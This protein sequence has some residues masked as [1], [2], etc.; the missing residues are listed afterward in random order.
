[1]RDFGFSLRESRRSRVHL[2]R[3][4]QSV[5]RDPSWVSVSFTSILSPDAVESVEKGWSLAEPVG[6]A[7][8]SGWPS[9]PCSGVEGRQYWDIPH[10]DRVGLS[11]SNDGSMMAIERPFSDP[12][13]RLREQLAS[14][15]LVLDGAMGTMVQSLNLTDADIRGPRFLHHPKDLSRFVDLMAISQP[16]A[17]ADIHRAYLA[18]GADIVTTN[19]F[20]ASPVGAQEFDLGED[21]IREINTAAVQA[22]RIAADEFTRETPRRPRFVA[23]SIGPTAKQMA[24]STRVEDPAHRDVTFQQMAASYGFQ[25][26]ALVEAGVD[27]LLVETV[28]D[29][30]NAKACL[31]AIAEY[32]A[33]TSRRVPV[34]VSGTFNEGVTFV[35]SQSVEAFW[36]A[37]SHFPLLAVGMNCALGPE[38]MRSMIQELSQVATVPISCHPNAGLPNEMGHYDLSPKAMARVLNEFLREGWLN[39]VGGCCGTTPDHIRAIAA[40]AE[41]ARPHLPR[42]S[43]HFTQLS[44]TL[45]LTI[46]PDANFT[47]IGERTNVTGSRK[48]ANL[49]RGNRY[50]EAVEVARQQVQSG[51]SVIDVNM[52]DALLDGE[53]AITRFLHLIAGETDI[54]G[55]PVMVDSSN[56][57]VLEAGLRCLQGKGIVNSI[58]LKDGEEEFLRRA[59]LVRRYGAAAVVMA[60]DEQGQAVDAER[61]VTICERAYRLLTQ[62]VGFPPQDII[63][64]PNILTVAT[65]IEEHDGYAISFM[66]AARDIKRRCPYAKVSGGVSNISFSFRGNDV[67]REAMHAAFLYHA[68]RA[69]L[70][71]GIVNA[72]QLALYEDIPPELKAHVE[73]VLLNRRSDATDRLLLLADSVKGQGSTR[74]SQEDSVLARYDRHG[75]HPVRSVARDRSFHRGRHGAGTAAIGMLLGHYRRPDDG[76]DVDRRGPLRCGKDVSAAGRQVGT[77]HEESGGVSGTVHGSG[78]GR[79]RQRFIIDARHHYHGHR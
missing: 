14:R 2:R 3:R 20:G 4:D 63:F 15:V 78:K 49:I 32:F 28:I 74:T 75:T 25:V 6:V 21:V 1:M 56:W 23:G 22:A 24:I 5:P 68:I 29:T 7:G 71:M 52:D 62:Q 67:V 42:R 17:L 43:D 27:I 11:D 19:T 33:E 48:F 64:D 72:G 69:G 13:S 50:E 37:V 61:K 41:D 79:P 31:F 58:S 54:N 39:I 73:D 47:M 65:G 12:E 70:D 57:A 38:K 51:A 26:A 40:V 16:E 10:P 66:E 35:S 8:D 53:A 59:R 46:R 60:F 45:P 9:F 18:A 36:I 30:L 44:G 77:R 76:G 34:I 55:V